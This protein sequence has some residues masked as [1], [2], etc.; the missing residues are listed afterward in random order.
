MAKSISS[1]LKPSAA[2]I[3]PT[4]DALFSSSTGP[5]VPTA[6]RPGAQRRSFS[7]AEKLS[8]NDEHALPE[9][10][11]ETG[12]PDETD[13]EGDN[14]SGDEV[15]ESTESLSESENEAT[16]T[17]DEDELMN[18][19]IPGTTDIL[20][21]RPDKKRKR[22]EATEDLEERH[23]RKLMQ[24][25][26]DKEPPNK[27]QKGAEGESTETGVKAL[28]SSTDSEEN[29]GEDIKPVHESLT[30]DSKAVDV[31]KANRTVFLANVAT[32]AVSSKEA[33]KTLRTHL[34]SVLDQS[35]SPKERIESIRFRSLAF[36]SLAL[37]KRAA[38]I[39]KSL[40]DATTKSCNAYV[41]FS[42]PA[43]ARKAV[44]SLNGTTV[45]G[46]HL[47]VDSVAHPGKADHRRC[48]FVG[49]LAFVD[50]ETVLNTD[51]EGNTGSKKRYKVPSDVEEGLWR[52][53][54][55]R[56]G[57]VENVR[58]IRDP[59]TRVGKGF[60]YVQFYDANH[61]EAAL[62]LD[63]KKFP[64]LLP[65]NLRVTRA[66]NPQKTA[67]AMK[68]RILV[69]SNASATPGSAKYK[70]KVTPEE[71]SMAGRASKLLG[72][73]GAARKVRGGKKGSTARYDSKSSAD[74]KTP[75]E[76]V[77][78]GKRASAKDGVKFGKR[79]KFRKAGPK[80]L[81]GKRA[82]RAADWKKK[83]LDGAAD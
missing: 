77:F 61:V 42:T 22:K 81:Q 55:E 26:R 45:L 62:L 20:V 82:Q 71:Q 2:T 12:S 13:P 47:R 11:T 43:A 19:F 34:S 58:V 57:K 69:P 40:M 76:I 67:Q 41:V 75:E 66:K 83:K 35:A 28:D 9:A 3:D 50:D 79:P 18:D 52:I 15:P 32:E 48:V 54:G 38:Y 73:A 24:G 60:A 8:R 30:Q 7:T 17:A 4:L 25:T 29:N 21:A 31:E 68:K 65:R 78:E 1:I 59:K 70:P 23:M 64:P 10:S 37:P 80:K 33:A 46:R 16:E 5:T 44:S 74:L 51:K 72:V 56:A 6:K 14:D 39:T 53:F 49:N 27:R 36:S 63:G